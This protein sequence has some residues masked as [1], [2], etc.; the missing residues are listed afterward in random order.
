MELKSYQQQALTTIETYL[1]ELKKWHETYT[2]LPE[3][4]RTA[5]DYSKEAWK[6]VSNE[7]YHPKETGTGHSLPNFC[8]KV[9][10]GGGK[11]YLAVQSIDRIQGLLHERKNGLVLWIVPTNQIYRQ[12]LFYLR[13]RTHPYRQFLDVTTG[14]RVMVI[15]KGDRFQ[16]RDVQERLVILLLM[17][18]SAN[19][20]NKETLKVFQ[21]ADGFEAFFPP[22][23]RPDE[24]KEIL[25]KFQNLDCF[26][27]EEDFY[28]W[29]VKSSLGNVLR[30]LS[31]VIIVDEGQ[32]TY[33]KGAQATIRGFNPSILVEL[34][35]TPPQESNV[36]VNIKGRE[37]D[38]EE[39]IK[40]DLHITNKG[41]AT[42]HGILK[43]SVEWRY[44]LEKE[45]LEFE[46]K[47]GRYIRPISLIQVERTG[48]EQIKSGYIHAEHVVEEL[49]KVH[50]IPRDQIAVKSSEKDDIEGIDLLSADCPIRYIVTKQALQEG[51]D[52][53]FA[54]VLTVLTN[55]S[56][57]T[58]M[59]QL[60]G[61]ILRQP[62][63]KKT[64]YKRLDESY[65]FCFQKQAGKLLSYIRGGLQGEGL[66]D[67]AHG[68]TVSEDDP[69]TKERRLVGI[70]ERFKQFEGKVYLPQFIIQEDDRVEKIRYEMD[71]VQRIQWDRVSFRA[72]EE[73][74]LKEKKMSDLESGLGYDD[75]EAEVLIETMSEWHYVSAHLDAMMITRRLVSVVPN[76]WVANEMTQ[77]ALSIL[78]K[79][80]SEEMLA[81][82]QVFIMEELLKMLESERDRLCH[83]IFIQ[84]VEQGKLRFVLMEGQAYQVPKH[85]E[86]PNRNLKPLTDDDT[87]KS[88][89]LSLFD[90]P[91][92][93]ED[94]NDLERSVA[95]YLEKQ[96]KLLWWYRNLV[97]K[98]YYAIQGWQKH[99]IYADFLAT[100]KS[101]ANQEDYD[102][103]YVLE[104][105]GNHLDNPD[106]GY[107]KDVFALCNKLSWNQLKMEFP[108]KKVHFQ[109]IFENEW[110]RAI[111]EL[112]V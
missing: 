111:N 112:F 104:T 36:L 42:W 53:S 102:A 62:H 106:T 1:R 37:L 31:P 96:E 108:D 24:H 5:F 3:V 32:K 65:V 81:A 79:Q 72:I 29:Q 27:S 78:R 91:V 54:Y 15:E 83:D 90:D 71:L 57:L 52:C 97:S 88:V 110:E 41:S 68:I 69:G 10:T 46:A 86:I 85:I 94:F 49:V 35:A 99:K 66:G 18:P 2:T 23:G 63:A 14:G 64:G 11:T 38:Q 48:K 45:A 47:N 55:P 13:D 74:S 70:R 9:P 67:L 21:D 50:H 40:L 25:N 60:V 28:G 33:S 7:T 26:G 84:L 22:E 19:R 61:R 105:K 100:K 82:N 51:W 93:E 30:I 12:T 16:P 4:A 56:S 103:I 95:L 98:D 76:A 59:T 73:L 34:S 20:K 43:E 80:Y 44:E 107:K 109:V 77:K 17:L 58:G 92:P 39:M 101:E 8:I 75:G 6:R 89:Q 87:G